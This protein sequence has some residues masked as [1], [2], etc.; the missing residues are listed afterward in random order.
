[1]HRLGVFAFLAG[2]LP[3]CD[4]CLWLAFLPP[5]AAALG[6]LVAAG[7]GAFALALVLRADW[8]VPEE[9]PP[10]LELLV[11]APLLATVK[12]G[13][14][15]AGGSGVSTWPVRR[16]NVAVSVICSSISFRSISTFS[17]GVS[18]ALRCLPS[19]LG[20]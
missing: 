16:R 15:A 8:P 5:A 10:P 1:M 19:G 11:E 9:A 13:S 3:G 2:A 20:P 14:L 18:Q 7:A 17:S 12:P 6:W 4:D